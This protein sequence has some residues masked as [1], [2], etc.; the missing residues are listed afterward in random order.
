MWVWVS[1]PLKQG[2]K[3]LIHSPACYFEARLSQLSIKTRIETNNTARYRRRSKV[4]VSYPLKQGL[5]HS[6]AV[7]QQ[8][9]KAAR[10]SQLSIK[11]R[12]ETKFPL[13]QMEPQHTVWVSY[14]LKQGLKP[15]LGDNLKN[16]IIV[17][18]S[19]PLKQGLKPETTTGSV[20]WVGV[21]VSYPLKQG[22]KRAGRSDIHLKCLFESAIH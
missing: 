9:K 5:K 17:W 22:L 14:P 8:D 7:E 10:L 2:L 15:G 19:Y 3:R 16:I 12:I 18:V 1:Y 13:D 11:T 6:T 20:E 4:W 21:W